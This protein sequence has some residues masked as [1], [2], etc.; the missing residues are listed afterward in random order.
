MVTIVALIVLVAAMALNT[1][2]V[3]IGSKLSAGPNAF[4]PEE[5]GQTEFP[6]IQAAIEKRA[7][8]AATLAAAIQKDQAAATKQYGVATNT[9]PVF[10]VEFTGTVGEG[11][12]GIYR[13][14]VAGV[15]DAV[16]I[17]IQTGPAINGTELRDATGTVEF[18]DF[19][20]QIQYQN[21]GSALNNEMK[22]A[23]LS[24]IDTSKLTGKTVSV[25]GAFQLINPN[26]WLVTPVRLSVQ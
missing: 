23:V 16:V 1:T 13:V 20:N 4:S 12:S 3:E 6:K 15:P 11:E 8:S 24:K 9:G 10:S 22:K 21:A 5:Y 19:T 7:V 2:V 18:G 14:K 17:R 26:G 25:A